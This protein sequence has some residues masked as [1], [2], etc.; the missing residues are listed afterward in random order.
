M[1]KA[2]DNP[3]PSILLEDHVDPTAPADGFKRLFIDTDEKLKMIDHAS[4][5]TDFTPSAGLLNKYNATVAPAVT[6]D[7]GD[8]Y[9]VGSIWVDVTGDKAYI[10]VDVSVGAAVWNPFEGAGSTIYDDDFAAA[11]LDGKWTEL[12]GTLLDTLNTTDTAGQLHMQET[13]TGYGVFGVY[14]AAPPAPFVMTAKIDSWTLGTSYVQAAIFLAD[15]TPTALRLFGPVYGVYGASVNDMATG[16]WTS[17]TVRG[18]ANDV[19]AGAMSAPF[20]LRVCVS[21]TTEAAFSY[22]ADGTNWS[23]GVASAIGFTLG[24]VGLAIAGNTAGG[25]ASAYWEG[26]KFA[27]APDIT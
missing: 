27:L 15:A 9:A 14:Q 6:D 1:G 7:S 26:I 23:A 24:N 21:T 20:W 17:R 3:Y 13:A 10:A 2:S 4:L 8:G 5:V 18:G 16:A 11:T 12:G 25:E 22:S 19:N